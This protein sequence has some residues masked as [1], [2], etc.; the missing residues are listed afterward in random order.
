[1]MKTLAIFGL[2]DRACN[3]L[4]QAFEEITEVRAD[5]IHKVIFVFLLDRL[6]K[7]VDDKWREKIVIL[8]TDLK[9]LVLL[10]LSKRLL[11]LRIPHLLQLV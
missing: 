5:F 7:E 2:V 3:D 10:Y 6:V 11:D 4:I 1:M 8:V 9:K